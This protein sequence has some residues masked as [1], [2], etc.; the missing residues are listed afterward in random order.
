MTSKQLAALAIF[1]IVLPAVAMATEFTVGDDQAAWAGYQSGLPRIRTQ[2][3]DLRTIRLPS[4]YHLASSTDGTRRAT[5]SSLSLGLGFESWGGH[6]GFEPSPRLKDDKVALLVP[7]ML[8]AQMPHGPD[9]RVA[10]PGFEPSPRLKDDKVALLV[11]SVLVAQMVPG[12][13]PYRP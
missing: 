7:S 13:Q 5:L 2:V 4:W 6:S 8:V 11:P 1:A 9:T 12:G 3:Q 10:S